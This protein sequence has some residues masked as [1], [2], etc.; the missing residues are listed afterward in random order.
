MSQ[1]NNYQLSVHLDTPPYQRSFETPL[2]SPMNVHLSPYHLRDGDGFFNVNSFLAKF[3]SVNSPLY[4]RMEPD[5]EGFL[6]DFDQRMNTIDFMLP[7]MR[8]A[9]GFKSGAIDLVNDAYIKTDSGWCNKDGDVV[10][11]KDATFV[12][13]DALVKSSQKFIRTITVRELAEADNTGELRIDGELVANRFMWD[14]IERWH[15]GGTHFLAETE[16]GSIRPMCHLAENIYVVENESGLEHVY[17]GAL[18]FY[19]SEPS[20]EF[21]GF[22]KHYG[23]SNQGN[24]FY[25]GGLNE[26]AN[27]YCNL[28]VSER[29]SL[30]SQCRDA[31]NAAIHRGEML[32]VEFN[33]TPDGKLFK[34]NVGDSLHILNFDC[35]ESDYIPAFTTLPSPSLMQGLVQSAPCEDKSTLEKW[36]SRMLMNVY[37]S[38]SGHEVYTHIE[39]FI[40][41]TRSLVSDNAYTTSLWPKIVGALGYEGMKIA[42]MP[43]DALEELNVFKADLQQLIETSTEPNLVTLECGKKVGIASVSEYI[44]AIEYHIKMIG[45]ALPHRLDEFH[46]VVFDTDA[47]EREMQLNRA[48]NIPQ[49]IHRTDAQ[50]S[51]IPYEFG[52]MDDVEK[53]VKRKTREARNV[54]SERVSSNTL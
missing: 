52:N 2:Y 18:D 16:D 19:D 14:G 13:F 49:H 42:P 21:L 41:S 25:A 22:G 23:F 12:E 6:A 8:I 44:T 48:I 39:R 43:E 4:S 28:K 11:H 53:L 17:H 46:L 40:N 50:F 31:H 37:N 5:F 20:T 30:R 47:A 36:S 1:F 15:L 24:G 32:D 35:P 9:T 27:V 33:E 34:F 29:M 45:D 54:P 51:P 3:K 26:V 38:R 10:L 7:D